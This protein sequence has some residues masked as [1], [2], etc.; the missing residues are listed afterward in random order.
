[1]NILN[2]S[3]VSTSCILGNVGFISIYYGHQCHNT[4]VQEFPFFK[5]N[6]L[7]K[8]PANNIV[9]FEVITALLLEI[10]VFM[11]DTLYRLDKC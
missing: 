10:Q 6:I 8:I 4:I 3:S 9:R 1:M 11:H 5:K 7:F 2:S